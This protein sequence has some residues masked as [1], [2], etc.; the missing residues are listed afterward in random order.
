MISFNT[1]RVRII[2][3]SGHTQI[4]LKL[5]ANFLKVSSIY[6]KI[7]ISYDCGV[8]ER[9]QTRTIISCK[10]IPPLKLQLVAG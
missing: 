1:D 6:I 4:L 3:K 7:Q 5:A 2:F 8:I 10:K 9:Y